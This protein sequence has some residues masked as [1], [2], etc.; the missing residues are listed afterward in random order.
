MNDDVIRMHYHDT[1]SHGTHFDVADGDYWDQ[2]FELAIVVAEEYGVVMMMMMRT[3]LVVAADDVAAASGMVV[4]YPV[5]LVRME[6]LNFQMCSQ[7]NIE[8]IIHK[9]A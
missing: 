4:A 1:V 5:V 9:K 7:S 3:K 8:K 6:Y 2:Y